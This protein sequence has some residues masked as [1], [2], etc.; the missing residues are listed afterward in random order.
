MLS[1]SGTAGAYHAGAL[2]AL[3]EA[4]VKVDLVAG[5]GMGAASAMFAAV[6]GGARLWD[7][8]AIW[9]SES[10]AA[11]YRWRR[12]LRVAVLAVGVALATVLLP[13]ALFLVA[14]VVYPIGFVLEMVGVRVGA[15]LAASYAA[16][17]ADAFS[18]GALPTILPRVMVLALIV[19]LAILGAGMVHAVRANARRRERGP[20]WWRAFGSP[21]AAADVV[22]RFATEIWFL[23]RGGV[24]RRPALGDVSLSYSE[25][26]KENLGQPGFR[27]LMLTA[28]DLDARRDL[29]FALLTEAQRAEYFAPKPGVDEAWRQ[30]ER[31]D[32]AGVAAHHVGDGLAGGLTIPILAEPHLMVF[33]SDSYWRGETHRLCA[34]PGALG[35]LLEEVA[36]AGVEQVVILSSTAELAGPHALGA[37][38]RDPRG[39]LGEFLA[40]A[41]AAALRE[42]AVV[43]R[44]RF[45]AAFTIRPAHNPIGPFDFSGCYDERS[46][47]RHT[48]AEVVERGYQDAYRQFIDPVI[49]AGG[50]QLYGPTRAAARPSRPVEAT[51]P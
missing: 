3:R 41:E 17:L 44:K 5:L 22:N 35:R 16:L 14:V 31:L 47:R 6:D 29:I 11:L 43:S 20:L 38:R 13:L 15:G 39:R 10:A 19:L 42:A 1:G 48:L 2:R 50:D 18:T 51:R 24:V 25:L 12:T 36:E 4:G 49:G 30:S 9:R 26:L 40:A 33:S 23:I 45:R 32:L 37:G 34:R 27:E 28:F 46:D 8:D 7:D 21:L